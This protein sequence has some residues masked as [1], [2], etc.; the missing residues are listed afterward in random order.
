MANKISSSLKQECG[1]KITIGHRGQLFKVLLPL[2]YLSSFLT[3]PRLRDRSAY[4]GQDTPALAIKRMSLNCVQ[5]SI[6]WRQF[7]TWGSL[8]PDDSSFCQVDKHWTQNALLKCF[9]MRSFYLDPFKTY[10]DY[11]S[12]VNINF[13]DLFMQTLSHLWVL[14]WGFYSEDLFKENLVG[15][16]FFPLLNQN[17]IIIQKIPLLIS[18]IFPLHT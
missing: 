3:N 11:N 2:T 18:C 8:F 5:K 15:G 12:F 6:W 13:Y 1:T 14:N 10:K 4:S 7:L 16:F 17:M 9:P